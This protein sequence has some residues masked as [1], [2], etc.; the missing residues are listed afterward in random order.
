MYICL[1]VLLF[2]CLFWVDEQF[3]SYLATVTITGDGAANLDLC[4]ALT[5]FSIEGSFTCHTY[6][7]TGPLFLRSY[8]DWLI[9]YGFTSRSRIFHLYGDVTIAGEGLQNLGLCSALRAFEQGGIFIV[10]HLLW[11]GA[12]VF[13]VSSEGPPHL[14]ASY[15]T[16]GDVEDLF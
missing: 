10:P 3:F 14:V 5:A 11:H 16:R 9:I 7:N 2:V 12:S 15:D 8:L 1:D 6:C 4:L 13:P